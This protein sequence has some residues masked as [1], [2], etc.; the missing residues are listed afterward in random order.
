MKTFAVLSAAAVVAAATCV[1]AGIEVHN[2][3]KSVESSTFVTYF[4]NDVS[5]EP[6]YF[7]INRIKTTVFTYQDWQLSP[8]VYANCPLGGDALCSGEYET[9]V[10]AYRS[11]GGDFEERA[12]PGGSKLAC[13]SV[14]SA[15]GEPEFMDVADYI[16]GENAEGETIFFAF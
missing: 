11:H 8:G 5:S 12:Y 1:A 7:P 10:Y 16:F 4:F 6:S 14:N 13:S 15:E 3:K 9:P 2:N